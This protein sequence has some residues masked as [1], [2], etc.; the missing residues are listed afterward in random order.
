[1]PADTGQETDG[2]SEEWDMKHKV[3]NTRN[4]AIAVGVLF[5]VLVGTVFV[6][7]RKINSLYTATV[8]LQESLG[9]GV[10]FY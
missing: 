8:G 1:N 2:Q 5:I 9:C 4:L 6:L 7:N 3:I 10:R